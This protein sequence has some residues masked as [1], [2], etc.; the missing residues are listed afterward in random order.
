MKAY[1]CYNY[2]IFVSSIGSAISAY[3]D[4]IGNYGKNDGALDMRM[5]TWEGPVM[6]SQP[7]VTI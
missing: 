7:E 1:D 5:A 4:F 6:R 3:G 2:S